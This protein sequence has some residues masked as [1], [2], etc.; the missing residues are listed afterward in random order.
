MSDVKGGLGSFAKKSIAAG[1]AGAIVFVLAQEIAGYP[2]NIAEFM[3]NQLTSR[4][5]LPESMSL[6]FGWA[7]HVTIAIGYAALFGAAVASPMLRSPAGGVRFIPAVVLALVLG[8]V[9]G[10][11]APPAI[12][13]TLGLLTGEGLPAALPLLNLSFGFA[14]WNHIGFF[15]VCLLVLVIIPASRAGSRRGGSAASSEADG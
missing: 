2:Q 14:I 9:A 1:V 12:S 11:I 13:A 6:V 5:P 3:G 10:V 15:I 8:Y 7:I 4:G